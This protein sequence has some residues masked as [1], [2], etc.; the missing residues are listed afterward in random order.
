MW[1]DA[2]GRIDGIR[3]M[4][5]NKKYPIRKIRGQALKD[6]EVNRT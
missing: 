5:G 2:I 4:P 1:K 3:N 6:S